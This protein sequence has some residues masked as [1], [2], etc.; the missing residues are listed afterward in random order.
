ML[1]RSQADH[2]VAPPGVP[3][4]APQAVMPFTQPE[5][6]VVHQA[7]ALSMLAPFDVCSQRSMQPKHRFTITVAVVV[8]P[9]VMS[10]SP[11]V[12]PVAVAVAILPTGTPVHE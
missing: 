4:G 10:C 9:V 2:R 12:R 5:A 3:R 8:R 6:V 1:I 11:A 7:A